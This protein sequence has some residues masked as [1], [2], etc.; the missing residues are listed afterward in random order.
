[1]YVANPVSI[2]GFNLLIKLRIGPFG[3]YGFSYP[4]LIDFHT[5]EIS[6]DSILI[7]SDWV[8]YP[9]RECF[10]DTTGSLISNFN[11]LFARGQPADTSLPY[12]KYLWVKGWAHP[13]SFIPPSLNYRLLFKFGVD[14]SCIC[15]SDTLRSVIFDIPF[16]HLIDYEHGFVHPYRY[17]M[18]ELFAWWSVPGDANNDS[19][20]S[21]ADITFLINYLFKGGPLSC[22][23]EAADVDSNCIVN[24]AD[25][26]Y[27]TSYLYKG[28]P[29]PKRGCYCPYLKEEKQTSTFSK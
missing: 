11:S 26:V 28:G 16:A 21:S 15:D 22:I 2:S 20:L 14:L 29:P 19:V 10:I 4:S 24:S 8:D 6:E 18:G 13:D 5:T 9:V 3:E 12:C 23:P 17:D 1:V 27:L 7:G 25:I